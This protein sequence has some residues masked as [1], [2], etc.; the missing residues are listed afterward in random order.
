MKLNEIQREQERKTRD[1]K[2]GFHKNSTHSTNDFILQ[3]NDKNTTIIFLDSNGLALKINANQAKSNLDSRL[4]MSNLIHIYNE[5]N[6]TKIDIF[7]KHNTIIDIYELAKNYSEYGI[8][9][10]LLH[11]NNT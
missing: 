3:T 1:S 5:N 6:Q 11:S 9:L 4:S 10:D 7:T 2:N 8:N